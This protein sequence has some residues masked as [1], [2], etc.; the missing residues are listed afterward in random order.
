MVAARP[1]VDPAELASTFV[2]LRDVGV[3]PGIWPLLS[4]EDGY[5]PSERTVRE[6]TAYA[7]GWLDALEAHDAL[8]VWLAVDLEPP[9]AQATRL[10]LA[11][12]ELGRENMDVDRFEHSRGLFREFCGTVQ[13]RGVRTLAVTLPSA[14]HDLRDDVPLWQDMLETPW[15]DIPWDVAGIMAYGSIV[16]GASRGLL[17][18]ADARA[19]HQPLLQRVHDRFGTGAHASLGVTGVGVFGDEPSWSSPADLAADVAAARAAGISDIAVFCLEGIL[20]RPNPEAWFE[21]LSTTA[22]GEP[23]QTWKAHAVRHGARAARHA[24]RWWF[25]R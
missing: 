23:E 10:P 5:W 22:A 14:A 9:L 18:D 12:W 21:A 15:A 20:A 1:D 6:W 8:P 25:A 11:A 19:I 2:Q 17:T 3:E 4:H 13:A 24:A 7:V 16:A